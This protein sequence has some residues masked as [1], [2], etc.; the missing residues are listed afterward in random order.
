MTLPNFLVIGAEKSGTTSLDYYLKQHPQIFMSEMKEPRFFAPEFYTTFYHGPRVGKRTLPME[1]DEY[2]SLFERTSGEV[3]IG[4]VSPQYLYIESSCQRIADLLPEVKLIAVLRNP[5]ERAF[6]AYSYQLTCGYDLEI[7]FEDALELEAQRVQEQWRP[8]W[9][10]KSLGFYFGQLRRFF[11]AFPP[12]NIQVLLYDDLRRDAIAFAQS[13]YGFLGVDADFVPDTTAKNIS[14]PPKSR[15]L[16]N[17]FYRDNPLKTGAKAVLPKG[18]RKGVKDFVKRRN[19]QPKPHLAIETRR[20][21]VEDYRQDIDQLQSL[22]G[23]DLSLWL[24]D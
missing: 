11:N 2:E 10:Y 3:K 22:I 5:V 13:A 16:Y 4:E 6:S 17:L 19:T 24:A 15:R 21:L 8:V 9:H 23:R 1:R 18:L 7:S 14:A 20:Q 12:E